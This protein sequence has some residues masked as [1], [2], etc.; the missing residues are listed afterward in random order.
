MPRTALQWS[1]ISGGHPPC[2]V[3]FPRELPGRAVTALGTELHPEGSRSPS[4]MPPRPITAPRH[5]AAAGRAEKRRRSLALPA[6]GTRGLRLSPLL[7]APPAPRSS[8]E[9]AVR[10]FNFP[11]RLKAPPSPRGPL[12]RR[13]RQTAPGRHLL[14]RGGGGPF[15]PSAP[16]ASGQRG[17]AGPA[18]P[19]AS[20]RD[21]ERAPPG[22]ERA[23]EEAGR[24]NRAAGVGGEKFILG[25]TSPGRG[26]VPPRAGAGPCGGRRCAGIAAAGRAPA[27]SPHP[28]ERGGSKQCLWRTERARPPASSPP[29]SLPPP[30]LFFPS[31]FLGARGAIT[32]VGRSRRA[33][34][35]A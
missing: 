20:S 9:A 21:A 32:M 12:A 30:A 19:A 29:R 18:G 11:R 28:S 16:P 1:K 8:A 31:F 17:T 23:T 33:P 25:D 27:R 13:T 15:P 14:A 6:G 22:A 34:A 10:S 5:G 2:F 3:S 4:T 7:P 24:K 35:L 26:R